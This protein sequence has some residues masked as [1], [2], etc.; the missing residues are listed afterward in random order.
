MGAA[1]RGPG[2]GWLKLSLPLAFAITALPLPAARIDSFA[3][4]LPWY[5]QQ[6]FLILASVA[7]FVIAFLTRIAWRHNR[8]TAFLS[9]HDL[10]TGLE[11]GA[12]FE[13]AFQHAISVAR[14]EK[15]HV[16]M[17][18]LDLD[19]FK[20][21]NETL[22]HAIGDVFL[23][24]VGVRLRM[25]VRK[26]DT[27]ARLGGDEFAILMPGPVTRADAEL[28][29][30]NILHK[31]RETY[32]IEEFELAGSASIGISLFPEQG[33]DTA[34]LHR[35]ADLAMYRCKAQNKDQ[36]AVFD[37]EV[38]R[39]DFRSAEMAGLIRE[40]L[41]NGYFRVYYQPLTTPS[42]AFVALE[43]LVRMEH[44]RYGSIPPGDFITVA[45]DTGL[46]AR[47]GTWVLRES[48]SQMVRWRA[49]GH[50][51]L[52]V[53]VNVS[54]LQIMKSDFAESVQSILRETGLDP[55]ALTLEITETAMM[56]TWT[57]ARDQMEQLRAIGINI[58]LDDFGTGY[59][60]LN[61]LQLLP[62]DYVKIDRA[63]TARVDSNTDGWVVI[64]TIVELA[65]KLGYEV[66]AEGVE[67]PAQLVG[68]KLIGCD[69]LQGF[70]LGAPLP[71]HET[72]RLLAATRTLNA[73]DESL[74]SLARWTSPAAQRESAVPAVPAA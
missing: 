43:A 38:N 65:H 61:A 62:L 64:R 22:G 67:S 24:Q 54:A 49:D 32:F 5:R 40:A 48:C 23:K 59:S 66:I 30:R 37:A 20:P 44:P 47:V 63:F 46:I 36:Y 52:R 74:R 4:L 26:Q 50:H 6:G 13:A 17:M 55:Y 2:P 31:L 42:G 33:E 15:T 56:R 10:L 34:T 16:A 21:I 69:L 58:A 70:L 7:I 25:V 57:Q 72:S 3:L 18:L 39:I 9:R 53:N 41:D 45:E 29:A 60:T 28:M 12:A 14:I 27:V 51:G 1:Q 19:R 68:L 71:V 11:N 73:A 8:Q 35:L